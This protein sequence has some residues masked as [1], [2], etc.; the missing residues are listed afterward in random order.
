MKATV[1]IRGQPFYIMKSSKAFLSLK[2][3]AL[4]GVV[5]VAGHCSVHRKAAS[6][7][8]AQGICMGCGL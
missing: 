3:L 8:A 5:Q 1:Q 4:A 2:I 6:L 7:I